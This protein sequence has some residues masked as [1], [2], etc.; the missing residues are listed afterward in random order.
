VPLEWTTVIVSG[1]IKNFLDPDALQNL[2]SKSQVTPD[3]EVV[4]YC[5]MGMRAADVY[6]ALR[7]LGY[8]H[9]R[10]YDG[11]WQEWSASPNL[12]VEK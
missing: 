7:L 12:P 9:V 8:E 1:D 4:T 6:F 5:Q 2:F 3:H 10:L 11:S